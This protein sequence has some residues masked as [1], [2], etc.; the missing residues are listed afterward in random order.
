[1][2]IPGII[3]DKSGNEVVP[4]TLSEVAICPSAK[5]NLFSLTKML[6]NGWVLQGD[7]TALKLKKGDKGLNFDIVIPTPNRAI[8]CLYFKRSSE[9]TGV[10]AGTKANFL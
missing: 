4:A 7:K 2:N 10:A 3:C 6:Q 1:M 5:F 9:V 8:Y